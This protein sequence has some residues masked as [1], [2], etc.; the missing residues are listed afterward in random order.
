MGWVYL[1]YKKAI[2]LGGVSLSPQT[3]WGDQ[4]GTFPQ[5]FAS[6]L[7]EVGLGKESSVLYKQPGAGIAQALRSEGNVGMIKRGFGM[8]VRVG[9]RLWLPG[10]AAGL[11]LQKY[12]Q[13]RWEHLLRRVSALYSWECPQFLNLPPCLRLWC[14]VP[15]LRQQNLPSN[16]FGSSLKPPSPFSVMEDG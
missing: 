16:A 3:G 10:T 2:A 5:A 7:N 11:Q 14:V 15:A 1:P 6:L 12:T 4:R 13:L 9:A 8:R